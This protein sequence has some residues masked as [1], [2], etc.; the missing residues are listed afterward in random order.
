M[1][2][3]EVILLTSLILIATGLVAPLTIRRT[4]ITLLISIELALLGTNMLFL[5][6]SLYL[7][8][9]TGQIFSLLILTIAGAESSIGLALMVVYHRC[10]GIVSPAI[11]KSLKG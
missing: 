6:F 4:L 9:F 5:T 11:L 8:D 10:T 3:I 2:Y 7:D 1:N